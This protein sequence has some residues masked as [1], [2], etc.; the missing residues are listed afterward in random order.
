MAFRICMNLRGAT[1]KVSSRDGKYILY[2]KPSVFGVRFPQCRQFGGA[3]LAEAALA[4]GVLATFLFGRNG[5]ASG[6]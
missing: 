2:E 5:W 1:A 3:T 6:A 4:F